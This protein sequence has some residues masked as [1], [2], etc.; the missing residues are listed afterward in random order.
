[1]SNLR[2]SDYYDVKDRAA[3]VERIL[4]GSSARS[5]IDAERRAAIHAVT[6][7]EEMKGCTVRVTCATKESLTAAFVN[8]YSIVRARDLLLKGDAESGVIEFLNGSA[9]E[10]CLEGSLKEGKA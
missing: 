7:A 3:R 2:Y 1:M 4:A 9:I 5:L 6:Q 8:T 10:F